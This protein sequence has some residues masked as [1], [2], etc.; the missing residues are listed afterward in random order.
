M[1][2]SRTIP[3]IRSSLT[4]WLRRW[5][6]HAAWI[7]S[8]R[9]SQRGWLAGFLEHS[10][11]GD[12]GGAGAQTFRTSDRRSS[13]RWRITGIRTARQ[14]SASFSHALRRA[15]LFFRRRLENRTEKKIAC[16][17][18]FHSAAHPAGY[19]TKRLPEIR[20]GCF[21][22]ATRESLRLAASILRGGGRPRL[23]PA[24]ATSSRSFT[25]TRA[26]PAHAATAALASSSSARAPIS[27]SRIC[28]Q[29]TPASAAARIRAS[30][31]SVE[32]A[33]PRDFRP[34]T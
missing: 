32:S 15:E 23:P 9:C 13:R 10:D 11:G 26:R 17:R 25:T 1:D 22:R 5:S 30:R 3:A 8:D 18:G 24:S 31:I 34:V 21:R 28:T 19:G 27:R 20:R 12:A 7:S 14:T 16:A 33:S 29:S 2:A 6:C 4:G